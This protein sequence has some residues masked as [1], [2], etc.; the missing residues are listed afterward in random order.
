MDILGSVP[1]VQLVLTQFQ[2]LAGMNHMDGNFLV[3]FIS[4]KNHMQ[5]VK[6]RANQLDVIVT[7]QLQYFLCLKHWYRFENVATW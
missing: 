4:E 2:L 3:T 5:N 7:K 1:H 6:T